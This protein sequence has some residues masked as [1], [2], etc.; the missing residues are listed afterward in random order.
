MQEKSRIYSCIMLFNP[1]WIMWLSTP[2]LHALKVIKSSKFDYS[3]SLYC[4]FLIT[5]SLLTQDFLKLS[6]FI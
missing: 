6:Q 3:T 1:P 4:L 2:C 5:N